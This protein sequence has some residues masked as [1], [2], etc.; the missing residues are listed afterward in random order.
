MILNDKIMIN[1]AEWEVN[2]PI[3]DLPRTKDRGLC[4]KVSIIRRVHCN[5]NVTKL[6]DTKKSTRRLLGLLAL[7]DDESTRQLLLYAGF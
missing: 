5:I 7:R 2:T 3:K 6:N 4:T 1:K